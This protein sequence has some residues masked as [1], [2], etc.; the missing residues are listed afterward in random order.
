MLLT[1]CFSVILSIFPGSIG[2]DQKTYN[3][4]LRRCRQTLQIERPT[5]K[6]K[7]SSQ[8]WR[9]R[10]SYYAVFPEKARDKLNVNAY[11][12]F[13]RK[14]RETADRYAYVAVK[15][16][17][18]RYNC[19]EHAD[20]ALWIQLATNAAS[21]APKTRSAGNHPYQV[22]K[23]ARDLYLA[24]LRE[25]RKPPR[26]NTWVGGKKLSKKLPHS[27]NYLVR[28]AKQHD[29]LWEELLETIKRHNRE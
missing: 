19:Y 1:P 26:Y 2:T 6:S 7:Y 29:R 10:F 15:K 14:M 28:V 21:I 11:S 3:A 5:R 24:V 16:W 17:Q 13:R 8:Y 9:R 25:L 27:R 20:E 12:A 22:L 4:F 18:G 23:T